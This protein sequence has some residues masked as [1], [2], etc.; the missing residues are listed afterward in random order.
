MRSA[1]VIVEHKA[2]ISFV[3]IAALSM[4]TSAQ[5]PTPESDKIVP[6]T[7]QVV[8]FLSYRVISERSQLNILRNNIYT[9]LRTSKISLPSTTL[10]QRRLQLKLLEY[11]YLSYLKSQNAID[12]SYI[13]ELENEPWAPHCDEESSVEKTRAMY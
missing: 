11:K 12:P 3:I 4:P 9:S 10:S 13:A 8:C 5:R 7:D 2:I 6:A 1:E